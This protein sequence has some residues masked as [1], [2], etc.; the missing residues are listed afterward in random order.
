MAL[1]SCRKVI[2]E[3]TS[4][5]T[6]DFG[7]LRGH[8][9]L[10]LLL[11]SLAFQAVSRSTL[12]LW[13]EA[14]S[15][16]DFSWL[17]RLCGEGHWKVILPPTLTTVHDIKPGSISHLASQGHSV[18]PPHHKHPSISWPGLAACLTAS[19]VRGRWRNV[20]IRAKLQNLTSQD[21]ITFITMTTQLANLVFMSDQLSATCGS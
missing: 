11:K 16:L 4:T 17:C 8:F 9:N 10:R 19:G 21:T 12:A 1:S 7:L 5:H 18:D 3:I 14:G 13:S 2:P 20:C 15:R 6:H